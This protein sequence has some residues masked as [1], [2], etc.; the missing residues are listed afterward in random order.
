MKVIKR[1]GNLEEFNVNKIIRAVRKAFKA[2]NSEYPEYLDKM[3]P[4]LF[5]EEDTINIEVI[6]D[7][8][9]Q[10][11]MNDNHFGAA[12]DYI[13]Y[14][15]KHKQARFIKERI[16]YMN[17]YSQSSD[18]AATS[19]ETD[20]N[21]NVTIKNVANLEGE[22]YKTTN[23]IIQ[24]QRMKDELYKLFPEV[25][26]QYEDDL[27]HHIIYT[28]DEAST[29][30]LKNYC[31]AVSL[32][33][34]MINGVG[35]ID[36]IT[37]KPP[38]NLDSFCGQFV[39]LA[40]LLAAQCKG[41]VAFGSFFVAFNYYCIK[42][43]GDNYYNKIDCIIT[44]DHCIK[45]KTIKD[46]IIQA[47]QQCVWG[48]N[49][50]AGNRGYQSPFINFSYYD[51]N[52]FKALFEDFYYPDGTKP[53]WEAIDYL[54]RTFMNYLN[55]ERLNAVIAMPVETMALL[56]DGNDIIDKEYKDFTAEMY[57]KGHSFFTYISDNPNGLASCCRLRNEIQDNV[58]SFTNGLSGVKSWPLCA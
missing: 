12:K 43:W 54:Q 2:A 23:R 57:A 42:E 31:E 10:L 24:R 40:F 8:V 48:I 27:N 36:G 11:L 41:A 34:L 45:Y 3:I 46:A 44:S 53:K 28:H 35:E 39:N 32:Y 13:L 7:R 4:S 17:K 15:D 19:S 49:Q 29:P 1:N 55:E 51:S 37:P 18:N 58:F 47:F 30:V 20:S 56:S 22:V 16:D 5:V 26:N 21:A 38:T 52:Y 25:A 50:P 6:Q 9:E 33:P 14:R